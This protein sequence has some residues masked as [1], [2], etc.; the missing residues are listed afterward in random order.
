MAVLI[1]SA[2]SGA[3]SVQEGAP[4]S[5][6]SAEVASGLE[7]ALSAQNAGDVSS[8]MGDYDEVIEIDPDNRVALF[9]LGLLRRAEGD[10]T[11]SIEAWTTLLAAN[12][13]LS[14]ARYQRAL[15]FRAAGDFEAAVAD[16]RI[17]LDDEPSNKEALDQIGTLLIALGREEEGKVFLDRVFESDTSIAP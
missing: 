17:V 7:S 14:L 12:P 4:T 2:C 5:S 1:L 10:F 8:A 16:L 11:G 15:T 13:D 9:N 6:N 3:S